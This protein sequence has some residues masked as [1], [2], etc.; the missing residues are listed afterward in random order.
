MDGLS[1]SHEDADLIAG[2]VRAAISGGMHE[3]VWE[4]NG[5]P[6]RAITKVQI[7]ETLFTHYRTS[8]LGMLV[9]LVFAQ[10]VR[11]R[12]IDY[13]PYINELPRTNPSTPDAK[14]N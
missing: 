2:F 9:K 6:L 13:Q 12:E 1:T 3:T 10:W 11:K 5:K 14:G 4:W 7:G 8:F